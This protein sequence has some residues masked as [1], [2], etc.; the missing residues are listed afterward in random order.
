[1]RICGAGVYWD[2]YLKVNDQWKFQHTGY[3]RLWV[4]SES[5][6]EDPS[7][8]LRGMY[9][10]EERLMSADRPMRVGEKLLFPTELSK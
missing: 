9:D 1:M 2:E 8:E 4:R 3:E 10:K 6:A 5:L 7:R